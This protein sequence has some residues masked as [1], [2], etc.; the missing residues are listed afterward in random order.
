MPLARLVPVCKFLIQ[1]CTC[2]FLTF[3]DPQIYFPCGRMNMFA[4]YMGWKPL[5]YMSIRIELAIARA[6]VPSHIK[7]LHTLYI[8]VFESVCLLSEKKVR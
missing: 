3:S 8:F 6:I 1:L 5:T 7:F 2:I 4:T